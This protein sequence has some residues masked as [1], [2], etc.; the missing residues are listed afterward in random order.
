MTDSSAFTHKIFTIITSVHLT[1]RDKPEVQY[2]SNTRSGLSPLSDVYGEMKS[3]NNSFLQQWSLGYRL[4]VVPWP[5]Q[6]EVYI[7]RLKWDWPRTMH[8]RHMLTGTFSSFHDCTITVFYNV[9]SH[10]SKAAPKR[11]SF[12][13]YCYVNRK[14]SRGKSSR[15]SAFVFFFFLNSIKQIP[16]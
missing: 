2:P 16:R 9:L 3:C 13:C 6:R 8:N 15:V 5:K 11:N 4:Q 10:T 12:L 14:S 1:Y 7:L